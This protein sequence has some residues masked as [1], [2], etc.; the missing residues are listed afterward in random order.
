MPT[1][2]L[3]EFTGTITWIGRVTSTE[4]L[5]K[6]HAAEAVDL[7]FAGIAGEV[8]EGRN[9]PS[10]VRVT[11]L[12]KEGTP[13]ANT[14]QLSVLGQEELDAI[15]ATMG[16][17]RLDPSLLGATLVIAG[18]PD[19][20]HLPPS[21]RLQL[22]SGATLVVDMENRPCTFP[23]R[24]VEA[25]H[26]GFGKGFKPAAKGRRG[27]TAW[28]EREGRMAMGDSVRLFVPDQRAWAAMPAEALTKD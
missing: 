6:S 3:T 4:G 2:R 1:L 10:C 26:N 21:S 20:T 19:F 16:L 18:L 14:R 8:H 17:E 9:R 24:S 12:Y 13:I 28:V 15:A 22:P 11:N 25:E 23:A 5:L 7:I 27:I